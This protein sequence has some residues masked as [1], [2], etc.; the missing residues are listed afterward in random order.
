MLRIYPG[1][2]SLSLVV[3]SSAACS[4]SGESPTEPPGLS[5][6]DPTDLLAV[7]DSAGDFEQPYPAHEETDPAEFDG[8][9]G[10]ELYTR[11]TA[12]LVENYESYPHFDP[13][14]RIVWSGNLLQRNQLPRQVVAELR[15]E[16]L[17]HADRPGRTVRTRRH[18]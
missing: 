1:R 14:S 12:E 16:S 5:G 4:S 18:S 10:Q 2:A 9:N 11:Q 13:V 8:D 7:I 3:L 6:D 15:H 17:C